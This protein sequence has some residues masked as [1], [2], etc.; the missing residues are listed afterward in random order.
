MQNGNDGL[1]D[2]IALVTGAAGGIGTATCAALTRAGAIV[3][4]SDLGECPPNLQVAKWMRHNVSSPEDW[5]AVRSAIEQDY[6]RLDCLVN[7]AGTIVIG[8]IEETS[9]ADWR[10]VFHTNVESV[11]LSLQALLPLLRIAGEGRR[12]GASVVN[13]SSPA[14]MRPRGFSSAYSA[15]KAAVTSLTRSASKEYG[16]L[17]YPIRANA[18]YPGGSNRLG[19]ASTV[20]ARY[21]ELGLAPSQ[22]QQEAAAIA[23]TS[24]KRNCEPEELA[25]G[26]RFLC[27]T[28]SSY[29]TGTDFIV[30]GGA[31]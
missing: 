21:I 28:A 25:A 15:S 16:R 4:G 26:I 13:V 20:H 31:A 24:L 30:D 8:S 9:L 6:G 1:A 14:G 3:I 7:N 22:A 17:G 18:F 11:L 23:V 19:M 27:S 12:G 5:G 10:R 2:A 29:M